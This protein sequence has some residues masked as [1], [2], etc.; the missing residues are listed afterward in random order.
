MQ[1]AYPHLLAFVELIIFFDSLDVIGR[2]GFGHDFGG[3][4]NDDGKKIISAWANQSKLAISPMGFMASL[5]VTLFEKKDPFNVNLTFLGYPDPQPA[6]VS[7]RTSTQASQS[8][9]RCS[10]NHS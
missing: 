7:Q 2:F 5:A 1:R 8:P 9:G 4:H 3:G 6:P 10:T